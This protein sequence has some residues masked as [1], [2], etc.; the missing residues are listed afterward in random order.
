MSPRAVLVLLLRLAVGAVLI[1][2]GLLKLRDP[3]AFA[4]EIAN[5]QL[6]PA[7]AAWLAAVL[8]AVEVVVGASVLALPQAWRRGGAGA[9]LALFVLFTGAVGSAYLRR[10]NIDCGC[11]GTGGGPI[12]V[13][14]LVRNLTLT[15]AALALL[16]LD[17]PRPVV[18]APT[19][20][21]ISG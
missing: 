12:G 3:T 17:R 7:G 16:R 10:I 15:V 5:Y 4:T 21:A 20:P 8:P 11:F 13:L 2:A 6:L 1:V 14:T 19:A 18:L 9:A